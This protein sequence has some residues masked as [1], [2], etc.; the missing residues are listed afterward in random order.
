MKSNIEML[1]EKR[2]FDTMKLIDFL[3]LVFYPNY[4][5][6]SKFF[7]Q[8][9]NSAIHHKRSSSFPVNRST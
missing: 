6:K 5:R 2:I 9:E 7:N 8:I 3:R 1:L 4:G